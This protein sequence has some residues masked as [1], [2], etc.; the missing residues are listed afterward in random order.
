M[1]GHN[2]IGV[3]LGSA[4]FCTIEQREDT[5]PEDQQ[6]VLG[7]FGKEAFEVQ[8]VGSGSSQSEE[9]SWK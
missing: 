5:P 2:A 7:S 3:A 8:F 1:A 6:T 4:K 9:G